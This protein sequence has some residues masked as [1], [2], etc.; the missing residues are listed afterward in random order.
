[1]ALALQEGGI[2]ESAWKEWIGGFCEAAGL[3][4][5]SLAEIVA[6]M[7]AEDLLWN[8]EGMLWFGRK[9]EE[10]FGY[11]HFMEILSMVADDPMFKVLHGREEL[12][13]VHPLSFTSTKGEDAVILLA[14]PD[15]SGPAC[16]CTLKYA[17]RSGI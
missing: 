16:R 2:G 11:R 4:P 8:D 17:R 12:G 5:E 13:A 3:R 14:G 9:G 7:V 1:M 10:T 15:G 6:F